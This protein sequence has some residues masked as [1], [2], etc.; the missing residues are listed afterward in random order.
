MAPKFASSKLKKTKK[1]CKAALDA[2]YS[3]LKISMKIYKYF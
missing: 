3:K 1:Q 2:M